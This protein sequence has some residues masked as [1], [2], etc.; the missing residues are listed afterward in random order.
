MPSNILWLVIVSGSVVLI[1]VISLV[2]GSLTGR[3]KIK[4]SSTMSS[5][6]KVDRV[7]LTLCR[8]CK[9]LT[10][11]KYKSTGSVYI[12]KKGLAKP[13]KASTISSTMHGKDECYPCNTSY[14]EER[15]I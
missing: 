1:I 11:Q 7:S 12:C 6:F 4:D 15:R 9:H 13:A 14:R 5:V 3:V 8:G 2:I 10:N